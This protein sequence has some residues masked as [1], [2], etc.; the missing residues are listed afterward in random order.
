MGWEKNHIVYSPLA[1]AFSCKVSEAL[2]NSREI[3]ASLLQSRTHTL[4]LCYFL[5]HRGK[6]VLLWLLFSRIYITGTLPLKKKKKQTQNKTTENQTTTTNPK[7]KCSY[8]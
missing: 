2:M 3:Q 8:V 7:M 6:L 1:A 5:Q 4:L